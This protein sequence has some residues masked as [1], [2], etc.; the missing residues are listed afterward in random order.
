MMCELEN[1]KG[2]IIDTKQVVLKPIRQRTNESEIARIRYVIYDS[3][4]FTELRII[5]IK[6]CLESIFSLFSLQGGSRELFPAAFRLKLG[7]WRVAKEISLS[8]NVGSPTSLCNCNCRLCYLK[9]NPFNKSFILTREEAATRIK[10]YFIPIL[11]AIRKQS[12]DEVLYVTTNGTF[13]T[14]EVIKRLVS[15]KP[16]VMDISLNSIDV[17]WRN[18]FMKDKN[19]SIAINCIKLL[20][21]NR[22]VYRG[23]I[24]T[25]PEL[26]LEDILV[27]IRYLEK[28]EAELIAIYPPDYTHF[29]QAVDQEE[30][31]N[32]WKRVADFFLNLR[33]EISTPIFFSPCSYWNKDI[34]AVVDGCVVNSPATKSGISVGD[35]IL[36]INGRRIFSQE[37]TR[38]LLGR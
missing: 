33:R 10:Y 27:T 18:H 6:K 5:M 29:H 4:R 19:P 22:I 31:R 23:T 36:A 17:K 26:S 34:S 8:Q 21:D 25:W 15:L 1:D 13:L 12:P 7:K 16:I 28:E 38:E 14:K 35:K 30:M 24:I 32:H 37:K 2:E 20:K 11:E 3:V 9:G